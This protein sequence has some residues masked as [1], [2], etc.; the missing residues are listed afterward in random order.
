MC[1]HVL[2]PAFMGTPSTRMHTHSTDQAPMNTLSHAHVPKTE[3]PRPRHQTFSAHQGIQPSSEPCTSRQASRRALA[4]RRQHKALKYCL[5]LQ[6]AWVLVLG[7]VKN[8]SQEVAAFAVI[9]LMVTCRQRFPVPQVFEAYNQPKTRRT[10]CYH[11]CRIP[12]SIEETLNMLSGFML[13]ILGVYA[14]RRLRPWFGAA[15]SG[16]L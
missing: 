6:N 5:I 15:E 13:R 9:E 4:N 8:G 3:T 12:K 2:L 10:Q 14:A 1:K 16:A 11:A 7:Y